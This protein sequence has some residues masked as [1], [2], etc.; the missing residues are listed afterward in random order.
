M[1]G[2]TPVLLGAGAGAVALAMVTPVVY[3]GIRAD[4]VVDPRAE[5]LD[6]RV[7]RIIGTT[8]GLAVV[9]TVA[10]LA[11]GVGIAWLLERTDIPGPRVL[12]VVAALPLVVPSYVAAL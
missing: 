3:L 9:V 2:R 10:T 12:G 4:G 11:V 7:V 5:L 8:V 1:A 6:E